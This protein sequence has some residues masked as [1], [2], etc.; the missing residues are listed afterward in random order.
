[1]IDLRHSRRGA[2]GIGATRRLL[3]ESSAEE[4]FTAADSP[5]RH[6]IAT[7]SVVLAAGAVALME[8]GRVDW[9]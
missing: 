7:L 2:E 8:T 3:V 4:I 6:A 1:L 5:G 9:K